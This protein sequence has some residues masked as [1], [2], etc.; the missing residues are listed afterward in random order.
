MLYTF[1]GNIIHY[2]IDVDPPALMDMLI[3]YK[4]N[5]IDKTNDGSTAVHIAAMT[6]KT[7]TI[8]KYLVLK[9]NYS[10]GCVDNDGDTPLHTAARNGYLNVVQVLLS[11]L[12]ADVQACNMHNDTALNVA[13][14]NGHSNVV[15]HLVE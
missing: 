13:A 9:H 12:G 1:A 2:S 7:C 11:E 10:V 6:D 4:G 8:I 3:T 5:P 15:T 14:L